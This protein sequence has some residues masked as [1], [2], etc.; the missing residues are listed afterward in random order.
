MSQWL[1]FTSTRVGARRQRALDGR[2][3]LGR[4]Q[5]AEPI[6]LSGMSR[7]DRIGL[8]LVDDAGHAFHV[9]GDVDPH[10]C[11]RGWG[12][13]S[14]GPWRTSDAYACMGTDRRGGHD[15]LRA[16]GRGVGPAPC[17]SRDGCTPTWLYGNQYQKL[18]DR[19]S[20]E[21]RQTFGSVAD[22]A[23]FAGRAVTRLGPGA[24]GPRRAGG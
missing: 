16:A 18:W 21:M 19:F 6:I 9:D 24:A 3:R 7:I 17:S 1:S 10:G 14:R 12:I 5:P 8:I 15:R 22:L 2:V 20:P 23:S 13:G 11:S 4:H